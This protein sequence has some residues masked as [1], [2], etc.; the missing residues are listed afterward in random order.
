MPKGTVTQRNIA[1]F[2][3]SNAVNIQPNV[4][5]NGEGTLRVSVDYSKVPPPDPYY[6]ADYC[7][8]ESKG[9]TVQITFGKLEG[10]NGNRL[11]NKLELRVPA[12][13]FMGQWMASLDFLK[14]MKK[15]M[16][17]KGFPPYVIPDSV[18]ET[19]EKVQTLHTNNMFIAAGEGECC[20]DFYF[21]APREIRF[22]L[23]MSSQPVLDPL[24]RVIM[25]PSMLVALSDLFDDIA[26]KIKKFAPSAEES[27]KETVEV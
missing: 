19:T 7:R 4:Q 27:V 18:D 20:I 17:E 23:E 11:R 9:P 2:G 21:L 6:V 22:Y 25:E 24:V 3:S 16:A 5:S 1:K 14:K 26:E 12:Y 8:I 15:S 13:A 10:M